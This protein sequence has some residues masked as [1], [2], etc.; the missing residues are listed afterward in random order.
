MV[1]FIQRDSGLGYHDFTMSLRRRVNSLRQRQPGQQAESRVH[2]QDVRGTFRIILNMFSA[3]SAAVRGLRI[4]CI[5][6]DD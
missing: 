2:V 6:P 3:L 1:K 5:I 4:A